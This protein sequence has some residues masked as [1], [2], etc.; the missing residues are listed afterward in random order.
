MHIYKKKLAVTKRRGLDSSYMLTCSPLMLCSHPK[1][2][3]PGKEYALEQ[4]TS[5]SH[6]QMSRFQ[7]WIQAL[8]FYEGRFSGVLWGLLLLLLRT[9][10]QGKEKTPNNILRNGANCAQRCFFSILVYEHICCTSETGQIRKCTVNWD[11]SMLW[12]QAT[13]ATLWQT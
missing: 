1:Q 10:H 7:Q 9:S 12:N 4:N 3:Q 6:T 11:R 8:L 5:N 13:I 2:A